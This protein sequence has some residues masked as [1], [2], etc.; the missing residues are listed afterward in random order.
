[1]TILGQ[2]PARFKV[3]VDNKCLQKVK[4]FKYLG[5]EISHENLKK[6]SKFASILGILNNTFIRNLVQLFSKIKVSLYNALAVP[7]VL[8][9]SEI[10][11]L[12]QRDKK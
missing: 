5:C 6:V 9:G 2:D 3:I 7:T 10:W 8:Y 11:T 1:M 4:N 12:R